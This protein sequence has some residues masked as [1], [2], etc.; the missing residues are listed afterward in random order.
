MSLFFK[1]CKNILKSY[2]YYVFIAVVVLFYISQMGM[3]VPKD[4]EKM[5]SP[6]KKVSIEEV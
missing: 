2:I 5:F 1:E 3:A 6:P 4:L